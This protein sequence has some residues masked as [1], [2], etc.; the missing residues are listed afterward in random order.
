MRNLILFI[1][2]SSFYTSASEPEETNV[3]PLWHVHTP[4]GGVKKQDGPVKVVNVRLLTKESVIER[5][6]KTQELIEFLQTLEQAVNK[7]YS[8]N[9]KGELL[10]KIELVK[11]SEF[12]FR[13]QYQGDLTN[14]FLQRVSDNIGQL[15]SL[16][17]LNDSVSF[18]VHYTIGETGV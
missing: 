15:K 4:E 1:I 12:G 3:Q 18:Q 7:S 13:F 2:F 6:V 14:A 16:S 11:D 9:E 8:S 5:N 17:P 10:V